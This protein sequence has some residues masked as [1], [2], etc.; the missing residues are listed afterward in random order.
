MIVG[1][2]VQGRHTRA[3]LT[4]VGVERVDLIRR[5]YFLKLDDPRNPD[6]RPFSVTDV[7]LHK[8]YEHIK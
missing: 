6:T 1:E 4:I 2:K 3:I 8:Y 7:D 5:N